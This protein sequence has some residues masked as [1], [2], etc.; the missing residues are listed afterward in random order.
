MKAKTKENSVALTLRGWGYKDDDP[1]VV[2][3]ITAVIRTDAF[4]ELVDRG[5]DQSKAITLVVGPVPLRLICER[6]GELHID[7]G[8]QATTVHRTH[9]CQHCG[10]LWAPAVVP[11]VGVLFLPGCRNTEKPT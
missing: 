4:R 8:E 7:E 5:F 11:T 10:A 1:A 9:A 2:A 3:A 6:C